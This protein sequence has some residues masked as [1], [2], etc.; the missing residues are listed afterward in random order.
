MKKQARKSYGEPYTCHFDWPE[1]CFVQ[2][3]EKGIVGKKDGVYT[4]AFFEAFPKEPNTFIRGEG[5]NIQEAE[6]DAWEQHMKHCSCPSHNYKR[7]FEDSEHGICINCNLFTSHV[8]P[9]VHRCVV[10]QKS[11]INF[12]GFD[13]RLYCLN[14]FIEEVEGYSAEEVENKDHNYKDYYQYLSKDVFILK[15]LTELE[16]FDFSE[17]EYKEKNRIDDKIKKPFLSYE[18][19]TII[20]TANDF[21]IGLSIL[22]MI[23]IKREL[24]RNSSFYRSFF[25][26][27][28]SEEN[29]INKDDYYTDITADLKGFIEKVKASS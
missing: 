18:H 27:Y 1:N 17:P 24:Q 6:K 7:Y 16:L 3:G 8:F 12:T 23:K 5:V 2:C 4:T 14:H 11:E 28:L 19:K 29:I 10:C 21:N 26:N 13:E 15:I 9:P 25:L 20:K 22:N